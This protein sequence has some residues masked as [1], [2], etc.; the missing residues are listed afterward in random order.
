M[1]EERVIAKKSDWDI[2]EMPS[3]CKHFRLER[4]FTREEMQNL[5][6][7]HIPLEMEDKWF[8]YMEENTLHAYR[9]WSGICIFILEIDENTGVH[10]GTVNRNKKQYPNQNLEK[11]IRMINQLLDQW[12]RY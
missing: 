5:R 6:Y 9:S 11:D 12:S 2:E 7:G 4:A 8:C 1:D 3:K 10:R